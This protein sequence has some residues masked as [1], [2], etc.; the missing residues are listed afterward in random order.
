MYRKILVIAVVSVFALLNL[1][2]VSFA[3]QKKAAAPAPAAAQKAARP[4]ANFNMLSGTVESIDNAKPDDIKLTV[5]NASDGAVHTVSVTPWTNVTKVTDVSE[6][7]TGEQVRMMVRKVEDKDV[8]MGIM[9]GKVKNRPVPTPKVPATVP[10]KAA[11]A[12]K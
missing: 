1:C 2:T 4:K 12:K 11:A 10:A 7:K 9:F 8:A 6:L 5:K 3:A